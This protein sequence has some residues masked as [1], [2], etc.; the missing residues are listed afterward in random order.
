MTHSGLRVSQS[1]VSEVEGILRKNT[2]SRAPVKIEGI[3]LATLE[4]MIKDNELPKHWKIVKN[5]TSYIIVIII[6]LN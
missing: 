5:K 4:F 2:P 3:Q 1:V 6:H